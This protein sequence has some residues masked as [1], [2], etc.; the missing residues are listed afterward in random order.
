MIYRQRGPGAQ[1]TEMEVAAPD[2]LPSVGSVIND[3]GQYYYV[4]KSI[5][6]RWVG[7]FWGRHKVVAVVTV[8]EMDRAEDGEAYVENDEPVTWP[9]P[10]VD[11]PA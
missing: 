10:S 5:T 7:S 1:W 11:S 9:I 8:D 6:W 2:G 4:V 3:T